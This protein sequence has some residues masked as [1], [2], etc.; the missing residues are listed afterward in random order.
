MTLDEMMRQ[1]IL[2]YLAMLSIGLGAGTTDA[3]AQLRNIPDRVVDEV[4]SELNGDEWDSDNFISIA[5]LLSKDSRSS[6][7]RRVAEI[8]TDIHKHVTPNQIEPILMDLARD[9]SGAVRAAASDALAGLLEKSS[10]L[11]RI[12]ILWNWAGS[13]S[14]MVRYTVARALSR[15]FQ[16]LGADLALEHLSNDPSGEVRKAV[17]DAARKRYSE[18]A[19]TYGAVLRRLAFDPHH[20]I[21]KAARKA[22]LSLAR[23]RPA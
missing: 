8:A 11:E 12:E 7:R 4:L 13:D 21:R 9:Y 6:V 18:N 14:P 19:S 20:T 15:P 1:N 3:A 10:P 16:A 5:R 23:V 2:K 22:E 17:V